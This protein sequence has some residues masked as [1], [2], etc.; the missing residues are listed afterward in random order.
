[1][2]KR[3]DW[4]SD[5]VPANIE[6]NL[7]LYPGVCLMERTVAKGL[8]KLCRPHPTQPKEANAVQEAHIETVRHE[9]VQRP[10]CDDR[11]YEKL[12]NTL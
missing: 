7:A 9:F 3:W 11:I 12:S 2:A 8:S 6:Q 1:M 4:L 5:V 10:F